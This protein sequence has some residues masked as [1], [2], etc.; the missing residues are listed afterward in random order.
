MQA[1]ARLRPE[2]VLP[3][4]FRGILAYDRVR[5]DSGPCVV[6][7]YCVV[8]RPP[9]PVVPGDGGL[10]RSLCPGNLG[11]SLLFVLGLM[12]SVYI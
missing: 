8:V 11:L 1:K 6:P 12:G 3:I 5:H 7:H 2:A 9:R 4:P 10:K